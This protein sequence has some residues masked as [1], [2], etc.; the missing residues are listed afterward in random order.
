M[1]CDIDGRGQ[2]SPIRAGPAMDEQRLRSIAQDVGELSQLC[3]IQCHISRQGHA[4][5]FHASATGDFDFTFIP[6]HT[7][8]FATKIQDRLHAEPVN[9]L[10]Q[11]LRAK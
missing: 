7:G 4:D 1:R 9:G 6:L 8:L 2:A 5:Q 3:R 11:F 10:L